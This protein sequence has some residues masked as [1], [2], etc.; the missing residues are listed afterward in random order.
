[1]DFIAYL[2]DG[3]ID[4]LDWK[5]TD[6]FYT[7]VSGER[8]KRENVS[9]FNDIYWKNQI[10]LYKNAI[11]SHMPFFVKEK[12]GLFGRTMAIPIGLDIKRSLIDKNKKYSEENATFLIQKIKFA[13]ITNVFEIPEDDFALVPVPTPDQTTGIEALDKEITKLWALYERILKFPL[14]EGETLAKKNLELEKLRAAIKEL[15]IKHSATK[16]LNVFNESYNRFKE[17]KNKNLSYLKDAIE[18]ESDLTDEQK[19][20][21]SDYLSD[22]YQGVEF[23]TALWEFPNV[24][25]ELEITKT[26]SDYDK[27]LI[28][29][30]SSISTSAK[31]LAKD[32]LDIQEQLVDNFAKLEGM[33][34]YLNL[35]IQKTQ[36]EKWIN[37]TRSWM[38]REEKSIALA[39]KIY[40]SAAF[41]AKKETDEYFS[42]DGK[43]KTVKENL[44][45]WSKKAGISLK[46]VY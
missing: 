8:V 16:F 27:E 45:N 3:K 36:L 42:N 2:P 23:L 46:E 21:L 19:E 39:G 30:T 34:D 5:T 29:Y 31:T 18:N 38:S 26:S 1:M 4:I 17:L 28:K 13:D 33:K 43:F 20:D 14:R 22:V 10:S 40:N 35:D 6:L 32:L 12:T 7:N 41:L 37:S 44:E 24:I 11:Y 25:S 15:Q 9:P